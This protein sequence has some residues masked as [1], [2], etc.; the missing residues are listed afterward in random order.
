MLSELPVDELLLIFHWENL[1]NIFP[2]LRKLPWENVVTKV[3]RFLRNFNGLLI[4][5]RISYLR[6]LLTNQDE[7]AVR[8][9]RNIHIYSL[10]SFIS[11]KSRFEFQIL[12]LMR[13]QKFSPFLRDWRFPLGWKSILQFLIWW[14]IRGIFRPSWTN[15]K[16]ARVG[17][18]YRWDVTYWYCWCRRSESNRHG[19]WAPRNFESENRLFANPLILKAVSL[20]HLK[21]LG[22]NLSD[23]FHSNLSIPIYSGLFY[24]NFITVAIHIPIHNSPLLKDQEIALLEQRVQEKKNDLLKSPAERHPEEATDLAKREAEAYR[25]AFEKEKELTD[26][27]L[28]LAEIGKPKSNWEPPRVLG[29]AAFVI[30]LCVGR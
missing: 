21:I 9:R 8:L 27:A 7:G 23:L 5:F 22:K 1:P 16:V 28:K 15:K 10:V 12:R 26:R 25:I 17:K 11:G 19:V 18:I 29:L 13:I 6:K 30:G 3:S 24:H 20:N 14:K 2:I 4:L